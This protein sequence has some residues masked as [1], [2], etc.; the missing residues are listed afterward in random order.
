[1]KT[2]LIIL[3]FLCTIVISAQTIENFSI[4]SGGV[5]S[6]NGNIKILYTIGE[7][8]IIERN[9]GNISVSEGF[10]NSTI[11]SSTLGIDDEVLNSEIT[12]FPNPTS[13][14]ININST[15][16]IERVELFDILGKKMLSTATT[17]QLKI[18]HLS[19]GMYLLKLLSEKGILT[20]KVLIH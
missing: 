12:I 3:I 10:V 6:V 7:V 13:E 8:N 9:A 14:F 15:L 19:S 11:I 16:L 2:I 5:S 1:M 17:N 4:D 18:D 20:K